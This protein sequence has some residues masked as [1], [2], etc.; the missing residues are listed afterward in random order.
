[1]AFVVL[2]QIRDRT[3]SEVE[4]SYGQLNQ[5]SGD[6]VGNNPLYSGI[7]GN[8]NIRQNQTLINGLGGGGSVHHYRDAGDGI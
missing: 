5:P 7:G 1:M 6:T 2:P 3:F 8:R 4:G